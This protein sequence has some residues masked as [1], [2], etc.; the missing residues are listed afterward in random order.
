MVSSG[1]LFLFM[2]KAKYISSVMLA[3]SQTRTYYQIIMKGLVTAA[4]FCSREGQSKNIVWLWRTVRLLFSASV[5]TTGWPQDKLHVQMRFK[6]HCQYPVTLHLHQNSSALAS[7]ETG[8]RLLSLN[9]RVS[10]GHF[11][12]SSGSITIRAYLKQ[13]ASGILQQTPRST[14]SYCLPAK[15]LCNISSI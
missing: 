4:A 7:Q 6:S 8:K 11:C 14:C 13:L 9:A 1:L 2:T 3:I 12:S 15:V 5:I 10:V